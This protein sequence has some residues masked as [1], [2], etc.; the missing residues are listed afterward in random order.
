MSTFGPVGS[1]HTVRMVISA[2]TVGTAGGPRTVS[3][4]AECTNS[5]R[6]TEFPESV[7]STECTLSVG[8]VEGTEKVGTAVC[9][10]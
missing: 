9:T 5:M 3:G 6:S 1:T 8:M 4:V 2:C 10:Q 7:G